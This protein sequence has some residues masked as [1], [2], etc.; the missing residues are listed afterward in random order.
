M[1]AKKKEAMKVGTSGMTGIDVKPE[2][3]RAVLASSGVSFDVGMLARVR[4]DSGEGQKV[5]KVLAAR[6]VHLWNGSRHLTDAEVERI[7][8]ALE[9]KVSA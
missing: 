4:F 9:K 7:T 5:S 6:F 1:G 2:L 3:P 8:Q